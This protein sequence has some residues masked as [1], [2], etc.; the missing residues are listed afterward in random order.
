MSKTLILLN[1]FVAQCLIMWISLQSAEFRISSQQMWN[2]FQI[3]CCNGSWV[4]NEQHVLTTKCLRTLW[5][6]TFWTG[7]RCGQVRVRS[8]FQRGAVVTP[9]FLSLWESSRYRKEQSSAQS[10]RPSSCELSRRSPWHPWVTNTLSN[11]RPY[12][13]LDPQPTD[14]HAWSTNSVLDKEQDTPAESW[15]QDEQELK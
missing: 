13:S 5:P 1:V 15:R 3:T 10:I 6:F 9:E 12:S 14:A 2:Y 11:R 8:G 4:Q 7:S